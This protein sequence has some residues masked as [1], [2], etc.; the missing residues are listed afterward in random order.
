MRVSSWRMFYSDSDRGRT[1]TDISRLD[2]LTFKQSSRYKTVI[3]SQYWLIVK[4]G[5]VRAVSDLAESLK[6]LHSAAVSP[7]YGSSMSTCPLKALDLFSDLIM[8]PA[9]LK[10]NLSLIIFMLWLRLWSK[11]R[12]TTLTT[13]I[14]VVSRSSHH[15]YN[16]LMKMQMINRVKFRAILK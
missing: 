7:L 9:A 16:S 5:P 4:P 1:S 13:G 14:D 12:P 2:T 15:S 10:N 11:P 8:L 6:C 3:V